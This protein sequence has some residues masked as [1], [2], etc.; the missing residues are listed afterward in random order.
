MVIE[1]DRRFLPALEV[2]RHAA[3][4]IDSSPWEEAFLMKSEMDVK[5]YLSYAPSK[6]RMQIV[7]NDVLKV[8][9][10]EILQHLH[11]P[12]D[13]TDKAQWENNAPV[14]IIGENWIE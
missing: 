4:N 3:G 10:A 1:K 11:T 12:L 13:I 7:M 9:E 14:T 5:R 6:S 2:L 8:D